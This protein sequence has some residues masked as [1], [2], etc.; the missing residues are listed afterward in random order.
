VQQG[1]VS[2]TPITLDCTAFD[3]AEDLQRIFGEM[4]AGEREVSLP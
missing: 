4:I 1:N 2:I 3:A